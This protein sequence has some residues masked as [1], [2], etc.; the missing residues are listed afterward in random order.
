M[1]RKEMS[2]SQSDEVKDEDQGKD[3]HPPRSSAELRIVLACELGSFHPVFPD[4]KSICRDPRAND[5]PGKVPTS[6]Y[7]VAGSFQCKKAKGRQNY[8]SRPQSILSLKRT[9][10]TIWYHILRRQCNIP[11]PL[12]CRVPDCKVEILKGYLQRSLLTLMMPLP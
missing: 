6:I 2:G 5:G 7:P 4:R 9:C 11:G 1:V 10:N 8:P 12:D 3:H